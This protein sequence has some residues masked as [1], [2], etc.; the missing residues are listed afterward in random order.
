MNVMSQLPPSKKIKKKS[1]ERTLERKNIHETKV[2]AL[3]K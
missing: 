2:L 3:F 1:F